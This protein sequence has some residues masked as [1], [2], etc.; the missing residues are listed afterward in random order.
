MDDL[1][2]NIKKYLQEN[3]LYEQDEIGEFSEKYYFE[4]FDDIYEAQNLKI[5]KNKSRKNKY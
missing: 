5:I 2:I 3:N 1:Y 4:K